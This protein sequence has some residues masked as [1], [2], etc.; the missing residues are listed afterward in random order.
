MQVRQRGTAILVA[1][2][3]VGASGCGS[4]QEILPSPTHREEKPVVRQEGKLAQLVTYFD[5]AVHMP[6]EEV[7]R[8]YRMQRR[9]MVADTCNEARILVAML[10]LNP[11]LHFPRTEQ[12]PKLLQPCIEKP[13]GGDLEI[14]SLARIL[15]LQL[16]ER[17]EQ[18]TTRRRLAAASYR[19]NAANGKIKL[20]EQKIE[21]LNQK[22]DALKRIERSIRERE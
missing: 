16:E 7:K 1:A 14:S 22:L 19:L 18:R 20:L 17:R 13:D 3:L 15:K 9:L 11:S 8:E 5:I 2:L 21:K 6:A 12:D 10:L 4:V